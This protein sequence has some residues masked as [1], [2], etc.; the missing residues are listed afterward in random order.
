MM[1]L[2]EANRHAKNLQ[3]ITGREWLIFKTP[4][5]AVCNQYPNNVVRTGQFA[6]CRKSEREEYE[7]G[8]AE[9][10][11]K[12]ADGVARYRPPHDSSLSS[13]ETIKRGSAKYSEQLARLAKK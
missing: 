13:E 11:E 12:D 5:D 10:L 7:A 4:D 1:T 8:G 3:E 6:T 9:F 2:A